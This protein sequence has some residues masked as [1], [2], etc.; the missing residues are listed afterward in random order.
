MDQPNN[1][2]QPTEQEKIKPIPMVPTIFGTSKQLADL[3]IAPAFKASIP[4][5]KWDDQTMS[6]FL[7][8]Y[9]G[10]KIESPLEG[11]LHIQL[12]ALH[13]QS[14]ELLGEAQSTVVLE[15]KERYLALANKLTR[16]FSMAIDSLGKYKRQGTQVIKV[17]KIQISEGSKAVIGNFNNRQQ[18]SN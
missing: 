10:S 17:E 16:T 3:L 12:F 6:Q 4:K 7:D 5:T 9:R 11:L 1:T 15:S 14:L 2:S 13:M 8:F 18:G